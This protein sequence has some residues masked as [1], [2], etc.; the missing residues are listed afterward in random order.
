[1]TSARE[2]P[3]GRIREPAAVASSQ[4]LE[5]NIALAVQVCCDPNRRARWDQGEDDGVKD[6]E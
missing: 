3:R 4:L 1:M 5:K 2:W 6:A